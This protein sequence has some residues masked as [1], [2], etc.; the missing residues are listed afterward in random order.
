MGINFKLNLFAAFTRVYGQNMLIY[1]DINLELV[2][3]ALSF[4]LSF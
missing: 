3:Q 2:E 1:D 4:L